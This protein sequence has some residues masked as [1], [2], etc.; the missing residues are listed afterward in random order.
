MK[1][2]EKFKSYINE[3]KVLT[4]KYIDFGW[5]I[6]MNLSQITK[7]GVDNQAKTELVSM[8]ANTRK[9]LINGKNYAEILNDMDM[10]KNPKILQ[11]LDDQTKKLIDYIK[12]RIIKYVIDCDDKTKWLLKIEKFRNF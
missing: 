4:S 12:P 1:H 5:F 2:L 3:N 9:P 8:M 10:M 11:A 7:M 6:T